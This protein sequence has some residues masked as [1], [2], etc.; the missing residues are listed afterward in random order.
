VPGVGLVFI[1][2]ERVDV[3]EGIERRVDLQA[4]LLFGSQKAQ[5]FIVLGTQFKNS[6]HADNDVL[7][8]CVLKRFT[9]PFVRSILRAPEFTGHL[10]DTLFPATEDTHA[11]VQLQADV[12]KGSLPYVCL[13]EFTL[14]TLSKHSSGHFEE[15]LHS[16]LGILRMDIGVFPDVVKSILSLINQGAYLAKIKRVNLGVGFQYLGEVAINNFSLFTETLVLC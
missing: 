10:S 4:F 2:V 5:K 3:A 16:S 12:G 8:V 15:V 6:S 11:F 14:N 1:C 13:F 9:L 7:Q